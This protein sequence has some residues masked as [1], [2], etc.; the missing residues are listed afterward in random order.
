VNIPKLP[1]FSWI[2]GL[3]YWYR[4]GVM[5]RQGATEK[6]VT[7]EAKYPYIVELVVADDELD[8]ELSRPIMTFT[9]REKF[10]HGMVGELKRPKLFSV[11]FFRFGYS[12][13]DIRAYNST[14]KSCEHAA[15]RS[16]FRP[17]CLI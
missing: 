3:H 1:V 6:P 4:A 15:V 17:R 9:G 13:R 14:W 8:V 11:V 5:I 10:K 2:N 12:P 7:N 16:S